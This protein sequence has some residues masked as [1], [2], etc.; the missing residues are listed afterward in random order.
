MGNVSCPKQK[1][2]DPD[3]RLHDQ[4][5]QQREWQNSKNAHPFGDRQ[6]AASMLAVHRYRGTKRASLA[7]GLVAGN[8]RTEPTPEIRILLYDLYRF[9]P[10]RESRSKQSFR[11]MSFIDD[12]LYERTFH[13]LKMSRRN[14]G[15][16]GDQASRA[17]PSLPDQL[18][19]AQAY[20]NRQPRHCGLPHILTRYCEE[21]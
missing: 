17:H 8:T 7:E 16:D 11:L 1:E 13:V 10:R 20:Q 4:E 14:N 19:S 18:C 21:H 2:T 9:L 15:G 3:N 5:N 12:P 6:V